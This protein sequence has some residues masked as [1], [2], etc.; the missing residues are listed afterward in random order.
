[1]YSLQWVCAGIYALRLAAH[2]SVIL[3][4]SII[5]KLEQLGYTS[6]DFVKDYDEKE[7]QWDELMN[8]PYPLTD[9]GTTRFIIINA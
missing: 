2:N 5:K 6:K 9:R 4:P 8:Q 1:M 3:L 7:W